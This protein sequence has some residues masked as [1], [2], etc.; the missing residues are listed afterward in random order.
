MK[1]KLLAFVFAFAMIVPCVM[2]SA[3]G[4]DS[5]T[6]SSLSVVASDN[7]G[8]DNIYEINYD[9]VQ[10]GFNVMDRFVVTATY[11]DGT[12]EQIGYNADAQRGY[13]LTYS[14]DLPSKL[15]LGDYELTFT[16]R[17]VVQTG[18][19]KVRTENIN[20]NFNNVA[21]SDTSYGEA[22]VQPQLSAS[23]N[24]ASKVYSGYEYATQ[25]LNVDDTTSWSAWTKIADFQD[26]KSLPQ[27]IYK[28]RYV[29]VLSPQLDAG[30]NLD[31]ANSEI[32][33]SN[34]IQLNR[35]RAVLTSGDVEFDIT[36]EY[37]V[38]HENF[39]LSDIKFTYNGTLGSDVS[40][41]DTSNLG[42]F[43]WVESDT[44]LD[45]TSN[46]KTFAIQFSPFA[47]YVDCITAENI[48]Y[49][50]ALPQNTIMP[51]QV[52]L[53]ILND[54]IHDGTEKNVL[55][56]FGGMYNLDLFDFY[57]IDSETPTA[58][59]LGTYKIV[60]SLKDK[61]NCVWG[62]SN[63]T[64]DKTLEWNIVKHSQDIKGIRV[65]IGDDVYDCFSDT[66]NVITGVEV[67]SQITFAIVSYQEQESGD[68]IIVEDPLCDITNAVWSVTEPDVEDGVSVTF[69]SATIASNSSSTATI[70]INQLGM[71][72]VNLTIPANEDFMAFEGIP[73][74]II[75]TFANS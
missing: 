31:E 58:T 40:G 50:V 1:G 68:R 3:C 15:G 46:G 12:A 29:A 25:V 70:T 34:E 49:Q 23:V 4:T 38:Y 69:G 73:N 64:L 63:D 6:V 13:N 22:F 37:V 60:F 33:Y 56:Y 44:V 5:R 57:M 14:E 28:I 26:T 75:I 48:V 71:I 59:E 9:A 54:A 52:E 7:I 30:G 10:N 21:D 67:G 53:P 16:Y 18:Y 27:G 72:C 39:L 2:F 43:E 8:D 35:Q 61:V 51:I 55:D 17:G 24:S 47:E 66:A 36:T 19:I 11:T 42:V 62:N 65:T 74:G 45:C 41:L 20:I 32:L